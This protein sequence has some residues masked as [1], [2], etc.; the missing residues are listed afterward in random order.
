[1][2]RCSQKTPTGTFVIFGCIKCL[3]CFALGIAQTLMGQLTQRSSDC[4]AVITYASVVYSSAVVSVL[5]K[6][7]GYRNALRRNVHWNVYVQ[8]G[9]EIVLSVLHGLHACTDNGTLDSNNCRD[10][11]ELTEFGVT[12]RYVASL[13]AV[14][15]SWFKLMVPLREEIYMIA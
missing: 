8:L 13:K 2:G 11:C 3:Q 15:I 14:L 7:Y 4:I 9:S 5:P 6:V 10:L 1:M 12:N